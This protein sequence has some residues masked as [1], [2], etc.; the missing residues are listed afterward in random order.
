MNTVRRIKDNIYYVGASDNRLELFENLFPIK[1]GVSYNSY[2]I[3]DEKTALIDTAD[4]S[5]FDTFIENVDHVLNDR[6]LD[7]LVIN[8]LEPDHS[9]LIKEI[10]IL[11]PNV[12]LVLNERSKK[13]LDGFFNKQLNA[14]TLIV[15]EGDILDLGCHKLTFV[16]APMVH[17]P[18]VMVSYDITSKILFSAD[19][20]GTF[21]ALNGNLFDDEFEKDSYFYSEAR[22]YYTNIVGKFGKQVESLL[23]KAKE[24]DIKMILPLHGPIWRTDISKMVELYSKW[25]L[26][27]AESNDVIIIYGS[28]YG[29]T[30]NAC[31]A[32]ANQLGMSGVKNIKMYD[33]SK[34][35]VSFLISEIFRV[36]NIILAS[37]NYNGGI[38]PKMVNL[39]HDMKALNVQNKNISIIENGT[40]ALVITKQIKEI[41]DNLK[42]IRYVGPELKIT[43]TLKDSDN[44]HLKELAKLIADNYFA[45]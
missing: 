19:A 25:A 2:V 5:V 14:K 24:L 8:H 22:R 13:M 1:D 34:T 45:A 29:N 35:D 37:P 27:E 4:H 32:L 31:Y 41:L 28:M 30:M 26:Y 6:K 33:V 12:T 44:L 21:G 11:Y 39:L 10:A 18:E 3:L 9:A 17:W 20:F 15:K 36:K 38:Y 43:T 42:N 16:M 40:W 7:Y 23:N